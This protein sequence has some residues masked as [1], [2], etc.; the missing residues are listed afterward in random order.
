MKIKEIK[1][2]QKLNIITLSFFIRNHSNLF[3]N[4][5]KLPKCEYTKY[6]LNKYVEN[7]WIYLYKRWT[8]GPIH[9][10]FGVKSNH[11]LL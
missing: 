8:T 7:L 11:V 6:F 2:P 10:K 4:D 1:S 3:L 9:L 5:P